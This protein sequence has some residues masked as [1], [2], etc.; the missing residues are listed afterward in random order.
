[1]FLFFAL[2]FSIHSRHKDDSAIPQKGRGPVYTADMI[3]KWGPE[4]HA[5]LEN[6]FNFTV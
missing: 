2:R 6:V 1:M 5:S 3:F 4:G